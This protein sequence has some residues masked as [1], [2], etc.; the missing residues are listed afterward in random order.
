M[1]F[2]LKTAFT[3][4]I[5]SPPDCITISYF[6]YLS[7]FHISDKKTTGIFLRACYALA[8]APTTDKC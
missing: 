1:L 3:V 8:Y 6:N 5:L 2:S 7:H 4:E